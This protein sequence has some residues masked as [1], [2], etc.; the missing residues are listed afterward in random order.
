MTE[1]EIR[2]LDRMMKAAQR[3]RIENA[4]AL[5]P[6]AAA[7][8]RARPHPRRWFAQRRETAMDFVNWALGT[9]GLQ[10]GPWSF[11]L[12]AADLIERVLSETGKP[13]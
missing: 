8:L 1:A 2:R 3:A 4:K 12:Q 9:N 13:G 5:V 6:V 11:Q 10:P 7:A